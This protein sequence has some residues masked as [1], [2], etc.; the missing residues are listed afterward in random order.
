MVRSRSKPFVVA[1]PLR[2]EERELIEAARRRLGLR[3]WGEV[4]LVGWER[5]KKELGLDNKEGGGNGES[6]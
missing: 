3:S 2:E 6:A 5:T 4:A 1:L